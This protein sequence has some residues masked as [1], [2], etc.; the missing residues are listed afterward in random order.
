MPGLVWRRRGLYQPSIHSRIA[1]DSCS[2]L[3]HERVSSSSRC[4]VDQKLSTMALSSELAT[5]LMLPSSP[6]ARRRCPNAQLV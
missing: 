5:R 4:T 1:A 3:F 6:A 2:V